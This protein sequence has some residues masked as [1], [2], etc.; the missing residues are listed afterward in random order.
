MAQ[1]YLVRHTKPDIREGICYGATDI[2]LAYTFPN[3][4]KKVQERI[5]GVEF[6]KIYSS[7]LRRCTELATILAPE[8]YIRDS[9]LTELN[10]GEWELKSWNEIFQTPYGKEWMNNYQTLA[11]LGGE[12][13]PDLYNRVSE[14]IEELNNSDNILIN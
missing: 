10:F 8:G 2:P 13:Y 7:P 12:S 6:E 1:I 11:S 5:K 4:T 14:F 9:R 3:E